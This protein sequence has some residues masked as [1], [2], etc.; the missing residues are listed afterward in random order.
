MDELN[1]RIN[2][3]EAGSSEIEEYNRLNERDQNRTSG[4]TFEKKNRQRKDAKK[5]LERR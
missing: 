1:T 2:N 4:D 5:E 3:K